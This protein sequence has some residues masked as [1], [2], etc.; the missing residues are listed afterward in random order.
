MYMPLMIDIR[1]AVVFAGERGE[2][3]Q[4]V[5]KLA[6]FADQLLVVPEA[7]DFRDSS[8]RVEAGLSPLLGEHLVLDQ[9]RDI[10]VHP[11][12]AA[13]LDE[14]AM[15]Q[16]IEGADFVSSDLTSRALNESIARI[17]RAAGVRCNIIDTKDLCDTWFMSLAQTPG[18]VAG[19]S[20][21]GRAAFA[22]VEVRK[23]V[24]AELDR[25]E[26]PVALLLEL[27]A[28]LAPGEQLAAVPAL[29]RRLRRRCRLFG[30]E[31]TR[32]WALRHRSR[33]TRRA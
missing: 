13:A 21:K 26:G 1:K 23:V 15:R 5:H 4:K 8:I 12:P 18:L 31:R 30:L 6:R 14:E 33:F 17:C 2:G 24:Q 29:F 22:A 16:V 19:L 10:P 20:T 27:R 25:L 11:V 7:A 28:A 3:L 32:A 9:A